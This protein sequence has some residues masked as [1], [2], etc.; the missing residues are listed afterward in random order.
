M[1]ALCFLAGANAIFCGDTLLTTSNP[2]HAKDESLL[3]RLGMRSTD[4]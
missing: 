2:G 3:A 1:Q 4:R